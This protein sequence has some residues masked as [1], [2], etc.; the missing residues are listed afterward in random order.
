MESIEL[1]F[2]NAKPINLLTTQLRTSSSVSGARITKNGR[3]FGVADNND[4]YYLIEAA[5]LEDGRKII[6]AKKTENT[7]NAM[8]SSTFST[9]KPFF[10]IQNLCKMW[11]GDNIENWKHDLCL[12]DSRNG[13]NYYEVVEE[14]FDDGLGGVP[15]DGFGPS[16]LEVEKTTWLDEI[17]ACIKQ[18]NL[19]VFRLDDI[20]K[21]EPDFEKK[22]PNNC[23]IQDSVRHIMQVMRDDGLLVFV[24]D[25]GL[26]RVTSKFIEEQY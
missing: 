18:N 9:G 2:M 16:S 17:I 23:A 24:D 13:T 25:N 10:N 8:K 21:H 11:F 26:Y 3:L 5:I 15:N 20:Y 1:Q 14:Q 4:E 6:S 22:Y 7:V 12:V 19:I